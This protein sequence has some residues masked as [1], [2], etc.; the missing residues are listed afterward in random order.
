VANRLEKRIVLIICLA[1]T[2]LGFLSTYFIPVSN[3][4]LLILTNAIACIGEGGFSSILLSLQADL[5]DY[6]EWKHGYR[7]EG[8]VI[9][10]NSF[11][12]KMGIALGGAIPA[13]VLAIFGFNADLAVQSPSTTAG[14]LSAMSIMPFILVCI[15]I[16]VFFFMGLSKKEIA[17]VREE[18]EQRRLAAEE[19]TLAEG[20]N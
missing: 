20:A 9:S 11:V 6:A 3:I 19:T 12:M 13:Y 2:A 10:L 7:A 1:I 14:I 15:G 17:M 8:A 18:L 4:T 16:V 5:V